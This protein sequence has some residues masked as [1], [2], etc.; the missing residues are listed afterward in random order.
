MAV[1][2]TEEGGTPRA[3]NLLQEVIR[4]QGTGARRGEDQQFSLERDDQTK[5]TPRQVV[6]RPWEETFLRS[7]WERFNVKKNWAKQLLEK[8]AKEQQQ[9]TIGSWQKIALA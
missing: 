9:D 7:M 8:V 2:V 5:K 1:A 3:I 6:G 4:P